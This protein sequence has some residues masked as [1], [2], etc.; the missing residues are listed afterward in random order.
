[1]DHI[2]EKAVELAD[3]L[4]ASEELKAVREAESMISANKEAM[5]LM[6]N[7]QSK[8]QQFYNAQTEGKELPKELLNELK[9]L[10]EKM[11]QNQI[12]M[13]YITAQNKIG[14]LL[15]QVNAVISSAIQGDSCNSD[16]SCSSGDCCTSCSGCE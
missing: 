7:Y 8:Q 4:K 15:H 2:I 3:L 6:N 11:S 9:S 12:I 10:E 5:E 14:N 1:M 16:S 13:N